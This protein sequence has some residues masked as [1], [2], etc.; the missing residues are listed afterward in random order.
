MGMIMIVAVVGLVL[1]GVYALSRRK[2]SGGGMKEG[3]APGEEAGVRETLQRDPLNAAAWLRLSEIAEEKG[4]YAGA[5]EYLQKVCELEPSF[6]NEGKMKTL[7]EKMGPG[8][9]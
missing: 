9:H 2:S 1:G 7:K 6:M 3:G 5:V 8:K 4:D